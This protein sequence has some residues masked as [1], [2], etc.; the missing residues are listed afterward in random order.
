MEGDEEEDPEISPGSGRSSSPLGPN[1]RFLPLICIP[2][3]GRTGWCSGAGCTRALAALDEG[4]G[5]R[6][7]L[8]EGG[9]GRPV[10]QGPQR[11]R[12]LPHLRLRF[13]RQAAPSA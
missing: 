6:G 11:L 9:E 12:Y 10:A 7:G 4:R 3:K 13:R 2:H 8:D 5:G 1:F